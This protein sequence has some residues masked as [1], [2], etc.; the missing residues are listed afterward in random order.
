M[1]KKIHRQ[2]YKCQIQ[3]DVMCAHANIYT[4][5]MLYRCAHRIPR[6]ANTIYRCDL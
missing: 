3:T 5:N 2:I 4:S 1:T 6:Y